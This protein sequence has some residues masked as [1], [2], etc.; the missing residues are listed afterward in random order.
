MHSSVRPRSN[1]ELWD[2]ASKAQPDIGKKR[3]IQPSSNAAEAEKVR[4]QLAEMAA[5]EQQSSNRPQIDIRSMRRTIQW[6]MHRRR[7]CR[8]R[9]RATEFSNRTQRSSS[10]EC[11]WLVLLLS[12]DRA[13][14]AMEFIKRQAMNESL[15]PDYEPQIS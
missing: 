7:S 9:A 13:N 11:E 5:V 15:D 6:L 1:R 3:S 2:T 10:P 4:P 8:C 14:A 12:G